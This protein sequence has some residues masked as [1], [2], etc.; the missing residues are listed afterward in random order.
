[1][2]NIKPKPQANPAPSSGKK[3]YVCK[4]CGYVHETDAEL[5]DDFICP[6]CK[7]PKSDMQLQE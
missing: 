1:L 7:H 4:I 2:D 6:I 5:S 3:T